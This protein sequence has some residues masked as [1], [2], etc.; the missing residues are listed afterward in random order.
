MV[1]L[2]LGAPKAGKSTLM[3]AHVLELAAGRDAPLFF[4]VDHDDTWGELVLA[5]KGRI[6]RDVKGWWANPN[7][8]AVFQT[9]P[10]VQVVELAIGA[11]WSCYVDDEVDHVL[12]A[13]PWPKNPLRR[14]VKEGRHLKNRAGEVTPVS[15]MLATHRPANLPPD[16]LGTFSRVYVGRLQGFSDAERVYRE[17]WLPAAR[18]VL[19]VRAE[20]ETREPGEF[21][22]WP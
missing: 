13:G 3:R 20:L 15:A 18:S 2:Y 17:G 16:I 7:R 1:S 14:V 12:G 10:P 9:V 8:V 22:V 4:I 19:E 11:G 6:Y 5:T 21:T